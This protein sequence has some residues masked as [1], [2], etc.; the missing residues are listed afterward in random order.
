MGFNTRLPVYLISIGSRTGTLLPEAIGIGNMNKILLFFLRSRSSF[1]LWGLL[2][3]LFS[4]SKAQAAGYEPPTAPPP[5]VP[6]PP[7][8]APAAVNSQPSQLILTPP[9]L[10]WDKWGQP[11][12]LSNN[13]CREKNVNIIC[14]PAQTAR[15]IGWNIPSQPDS[16]LSPNQ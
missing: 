10:T 4:I 12:W 14:L 2:S 1:I 11:Y 3:L 5:A 15:H 16:T 7:A 8:S 9:L 6:L 13:V